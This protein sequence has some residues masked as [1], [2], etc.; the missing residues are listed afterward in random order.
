MASL[1]LLRQYSVMD[2]GQASGGSEQVV[3]VSWLPDGASFLAA[4]H[5]SLLLFDARQG[6]G[7]APLRRLQS[8]HAFLYDAAALGGSCV[9][10]VGSD[11]KIGFVRWGWLMRA[12]PRLTPAQAMVQGLAMCVCG[13]HPPIPT[14]PAPPTGSA[15]GAQSW[16]GRPEQ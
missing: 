15:T 7:A 14:R 1:K 2:E 3:A 6:G 11:K 5:R 8:P 9:V 12:A 10:T 13:P 16:W 4:T